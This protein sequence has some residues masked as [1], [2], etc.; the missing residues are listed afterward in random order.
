MDNL[1]CLLL[2]LLVFLFERVGQPKWL[3]ENSFVYDISFTKYTGKDI[4][5][6]YYSNIVLVSLKNFEFTDNQG[7]EFN[8]KFAGIFMGPIKK[9][10]F[11]KEVL[12]PF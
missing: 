10:K 2:I 11:E 3:S 6:N 1:L 4:F 8:C 12:E 7:G 9:Q 5:Y